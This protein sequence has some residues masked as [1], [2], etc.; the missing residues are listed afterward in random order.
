MT[1]FDETPSGVGCDTWMS[2]KDSNSEL[3]EFYTK[4][5]MPSDITEYRTVETVFGDAGEINFNF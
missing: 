1:S 2:I 5:Q 4:C 3:F